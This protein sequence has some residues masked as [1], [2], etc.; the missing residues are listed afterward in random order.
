MRALLAALIAPLTLAASASATP[1]AYVTSGNSPNTNIKVIDTA[2]STTVATVLVY[3]G[4]PQIAINPART[5]LYVPRVRD[6][7]VAV[8]DTT[9]NSVI[10]SVPMAGWPTFAAINPAGTKVYLGNSLNP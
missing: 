6:G 5:R 2:T 10:A 1:F 7:E 8:I 4:P 3:G 9:T